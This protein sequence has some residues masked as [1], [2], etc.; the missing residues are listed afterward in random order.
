MGAECKATGLLDSPANPEQHL[1]PTCIDSGQ[2]STATEAKGSV[3]FSY[4]GGL[5]FLVEHKGENSGDYS[6]S[7]E[8]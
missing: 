7:A 8:A 3:G 2:Q 6:N 5:F 1:A 4:C